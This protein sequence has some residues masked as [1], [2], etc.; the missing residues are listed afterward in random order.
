MENLA[1]YLLHCQWFLVRQAEVMA[2]LVDDDFSEPAKM[3]FLV[4]ICNKAGF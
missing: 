1:C 4:F 2:Q 3:Y